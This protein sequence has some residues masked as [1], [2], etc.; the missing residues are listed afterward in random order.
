MAEYCAAGTM[1]YTSDTVLL[2]N[3]APERG[4]LLFVFAALSA[5]RLGRTR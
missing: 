1:V 4:E 5:L 3:V 2:T